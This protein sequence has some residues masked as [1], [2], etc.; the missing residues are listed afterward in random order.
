MKKKKTTT[1][2]LSLRRCNR[3]L[4]VDNEGKMG[5]L[6]REHRRRLEEERTQAS[7]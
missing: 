1:F 3:I 6:S 4:S 7:I 5:I 2:E